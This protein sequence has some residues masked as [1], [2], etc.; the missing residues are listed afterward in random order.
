MKIV[1][2]GTYDGPVNYSG[3][4]AADL[5]RLY[6]NTAKNNS[7]DPNDNGSQ[8]YYYTQT[9]TPADKTAD[10]NG[11]WY[12]TLTFDNLPLYI[13]TCGDGRWIGRECPVTYYVKEIEPTLGEGKVN[14]YIYGVN[15]CKA[16]GL[17]T[18]NAVTI[19]ENGTTATVTD[20]N[21][22]K[23]RSITV[24]K[25]WE[26]NDYSEQ[27]LHYDID[28]TLTCA[29][30]AS[31][32]SYNKTET[33]TKDSTPNEVVFTNLPVYD[34][35][36]SLLSYSVD[37]KVH[38]ENLP[39][40]QTA[41]SNRYGYVKS[42]SSTTDSN[43]VLT[44]YTITNTLPVIRFKADKVWDDNKN[45]DGKRPE[46]LN[47][48]LSRTA[49]STTETINTLNDTSAAH[50]SN[51]ALWNVDFNVQPEFNENNVAYVYS[52]AERADGLTYYTPYNGV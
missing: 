50:Y 24:T 38:V 48:I 39:E 6:P 17:G 19:P 49:E 4:S 12:E 14:P 33:L 22:L 20:Q 45:Q 51:N 9:L 5:L 29:Q 28:F 3:Q 37:E 41:P 30:T 42:E 8:E 43:S 2:D 26:D 27:N 21:S 35:D 10:T 32:Y 1:S 25:V 47:F 7:Y 46:Q 34:L 44:A 13:N 15:G 31:G 23:T 36:G 52:V 16:D 40:G 11:K 18:S